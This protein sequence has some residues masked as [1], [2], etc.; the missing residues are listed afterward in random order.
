MVVAVVVPGAPGGGGGGGTMPSRC[1]CSTT[2]VAA[3]AARSV[4][5]F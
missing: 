5:L 2:A 4:K 3:V 1:I